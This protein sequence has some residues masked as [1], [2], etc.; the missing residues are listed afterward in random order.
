MLANSDDVGACSTT[1]PPYIT[2]MSSVRPATTP[3]SWVTRIIAMCR[4]RCCCCSRLRICACTVTSSAVVGSSANSSFG[5]AR[6]RDG[7]RDA[8]A[9]AARQLMRVLVETLRRLGD[10]DRVQQR[11]RGLVGLALVHVQVEDQRLGDLLADLH[12][13]VERRHRVLEDH[14][15]LGAPHRAH[16]VLRVADDVVALVEDVALTDDVALGQQAHD[17]PRQDRLARAGLAHDAE[18]LAAVEA[19]RHTVDGTHGAALGAEVRL[20]IDDPAGVWCRGPSGCRRAR[21]R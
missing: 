15:H 20:E 17:R 7:D 3:R 11:E 2:A 18:R 16:V 9:H 19:E 1:L 21:S 10:P 4:S 8:L 6:E 5:T 12:H 14:R 13:R